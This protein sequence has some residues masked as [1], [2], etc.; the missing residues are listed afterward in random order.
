MC[1]TKSVQCPEQSDET[2]HRSKLNKKQRER[3]LDLF[4]ILQLNSQ[5]GNKKSTSWADLQSQLSP[6]E[7]QDY[8]ALVSEKKIGFGLCTWNVF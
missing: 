1:Q 3:D 7:C 6:N 4:W 5:A 2:N 8:Q